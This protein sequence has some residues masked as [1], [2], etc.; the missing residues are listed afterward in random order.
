MKTVGNLLVSSAVNL[1]QQL[2]DLSLKSQNLRLEVGSFVSGDRASNNGA[3]D[4]TGATK[5]SLGRNENV[6]D[7]LVFAQ[8]GQVKK[9]FDRLSVS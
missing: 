7:V 2:L 5:S 3:G 1:D 6:R 4:T 9:D 8:Q